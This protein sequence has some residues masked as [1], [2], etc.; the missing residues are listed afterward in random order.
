MPKVVWIKIGLIGLLFIF[1]FSGCQ[2]RKKEP[3]LETVQ[4]DKNIPY[5][6]IEP[7]A[8]RLLDGQAVPIGQESFLPVVLVVDNLLGA[9]SLIGLESSAI[10]YEIPVEGGLTR[11]MAIFDYQDL[12]S[13]VG[14]V[15]SARPAFAEITQEYK[16]IFIHA[17]GSPEVLEKIKKGFY[18]IYDLDEISWQGFY[19]RR[20]YNLPRPHNLYI[21]KV[22]VEKFVEDKKINLKADFTPWPFSQSLELSGRASEKIKIKFSANYSVVW[23]YNLES[24]VYNLWQN[25][26]LLEGINI[27][28][29]IIQYTDISIIDQEGRRRIRLTGEGR[30]LICQQGICQEGRWKKELGRTRFYNQAGEEIK[31]LPGKT[32]LSI[33]SDKMAVSY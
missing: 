19:F 30:V 6:I 14:P 15:R 33:V 23:Q 27:N 3:Q 1:V 5:E 9:V 21:E 26:K 12:S 24:K 10:I 20:D 22:A 2:V 16:A 7:T 18:K 32:W 17:G 4:P 31:L 29:L 28:N 25:N 13:K 11:L 8:F